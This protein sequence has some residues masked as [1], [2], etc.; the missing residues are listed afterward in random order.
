MSNGIWVFSTN[1]EWRQ[2]K[3]PLA[4]HRHLDDWEAEKSSWLR[5]LD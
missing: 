1:S 2:A 3:D 5:A 4:S